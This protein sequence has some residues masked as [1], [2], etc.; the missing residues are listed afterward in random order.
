MA[1]NLTPF[2]D[3]LAS[4]T[5]SRSTKRAAEICAGCGL[6][7]EPKKK[8]VRCS[9]CQS[10]WYHG[11]ECQRKHYR[12]HKKACRKSAVD[13]DIKKHIASF[14][15]PESATG[16][17]ALYRVERRP[18]RGRCM[19]ACGQ[20]VVGTR[21]ADNVNAD[22][23]GNPSFQPLVS[24]V[25]MAAKRGTRCAHC[26]G[27]V[28]HDNQL[29]LDGPPPATRP[30]LHR[31]C[32]L[33]CMT[34]CNETNMAQ[35]EE[36]VAFQLMQRKEASSTPNVGTTVLL[37]YRLIRHMIMQNEDCLSELESHIDSPYTTQAE[38]EFFKTTAAVA[39]YLAMSSECAQPPSSDIASRVL[40]TN[41][42][43]T[44]V[45]KISTN[46]FTIC[47]G[48]G[49]SLGIGL[50]P[51]ATVVNHSCLPNLI[52]TFRY[53]SNG[54]PPSLLLTVCRSIPNSGEELCIAY[55]D[56]TAP[57]HIRKEVLRKG[58][59]FICACQHCEDLASDDNAIGIC[60]PSEGCK[61]IGLKQKENGTDEYI[62]ICD[63]CGYTDFSLC[64]KRRD[65][66][67]TMI[68]ALHSEQEPKSG[69]DQIEAAY[70]SMKKYCTIDSWY[71]QEAGE[72][73]VKAVLDQV[74]RG[75][76]ECNQRELCSLALA[77]LDELGV[78]KGKRKRSS[79]CCPLPRLLRQY[80]IAKLQL[81][82]FPDPRLAMNLLQDVHSELLVYF[83]R[84]HEVILD[85]ENCMS[86]AM[87]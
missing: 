34:L 44:A 30:L 43:E 14:V 77:T 41:Y 25:L 16:P 24:P 87:A 48:E 23:T 81:F 13:T 2:G 4:P 74:G 49:A 21:L 28:S 7:P 60:C 86:G 71:V 55:T 70:T 56:T 38:R 29:I 42:L 36:I 32:S 59:K 12:K 39:R 15:V 54:M 40:D 50:Y 27:N 47:D 51:S 20:I 82:L 72:I 85:L 67:Y 5:T 1:N 66:L 31:F 64:V 8:L 84:D 73:F 80:K 10:V 58:Y 52:Q 19:I 83:P 57:A 76:T 11:I 26:F 3:A 18:N 69:L 78:E 6:P 35:E 79:E 61:G 45:S 53:G 17:A 63:S 75:V 37:L 62:N 46:A 9:R 68:Q 65:E 22:T 33:R